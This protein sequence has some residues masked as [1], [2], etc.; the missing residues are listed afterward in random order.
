MIYYND[1]DIN[2]VRLLDR[3][4][5]DG[6]ITADLIDHRDIA[7]VQ[8]HELQGFTRC[9]FFAGIGGWELA[10]NWAGFP[11]ERVVWTGSCPCQPFSNLGLHKGLDDERHVWPAWRDLIAQRRPTTIFGEQVASK[12]GFEWL[13]RVFIELEALG[14]KV[15]GADLCAAGVAAPHAR[16]RIYWGAA[17]L[18]PD[19]HEA[20]GVEPCPFCRYRFNVEE[21]R[22]YGCPNCCGDG[23]DYAHGPGLQG[24]AQHEL[25]IDQSRQ[26]NTGKSGSLAPPGWNR[27]TYAR[28][29][30]PTSK[31]GRYLQ[32]W[33]RIEPGIEPLAYGVSEVLG[34]SRKALLIAYGNA[35]VP[36]LAAHFVRCFMEALN[37]KEGTDI[38]STPK[39]IF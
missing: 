39:T 30:E 36:E 6:E 17:R 15:A 27:C 18:G 5:M 32:K 29:V 13:A 35:I 12:D 14:Y 1:I 28:C 37:I 21:L 33:R 25:S 19:P 24:H 23:L 2:A 9:H 34:L 38:V 20:A 31:E 4:Q 7:E 26:L 11:R 3:L 16:S 10:L 22:I 8:A